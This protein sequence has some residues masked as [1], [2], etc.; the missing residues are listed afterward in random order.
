[1]RVRGDESRGE[2][3]RRLAGLVRVHDRISN[4]LAYA[5]M[6]ID[7]DLDAGLLEEAEA[8][9]LRSIV[10][11]AL[12]DTH[13]VINMPDRHGSGFDRYRRLGVVTVNRR[14]MFKPY[15]TQYNA[16]NTCTASDRAA[17]PSLTF[18]CRTTT[19]TVESAIPRRSAIYA[20]E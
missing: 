4:D 14:T 9:S 5:V 6:R 11:R 10:M 18:A 12:H 13:D 1:M 3:G 2:F 17:T 20:V 15:S 7:H 16:R 8:Q 19:D